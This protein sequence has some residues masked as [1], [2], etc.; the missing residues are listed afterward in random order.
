MRV[1]FYTYQINFA[2][3]DNFLYV[4]FS[5]V[6]NVSRGRM[7]HREAGFV[8]F[9]TISHIANMNVVFSNS[10][11]QMHFDYFQKS[12]SMCWYSRKDRSYYSHK[13]SVEA[14]T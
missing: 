13:F 3:P 10:L 11:K 14:M 2:V 4:V 8:M 12:K 7:F 9:V 1:L 5:M 6:K